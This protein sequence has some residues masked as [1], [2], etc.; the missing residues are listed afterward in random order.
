METPPPQSTMFLYQEVSKISGV[1]DPYFQI[2]QD[3]I[4]EAL[5]LYPELK[6]I[7][8]KSANP[9]LTAVR[10]AIAG[11]VIDL[12][13]NKHFDIRQDVYTIL[14]QQFGIDDFDKFEHE[15]SKA[16]TILY[17]GD[18]SGESVFDKILIE[19]MNKKVYYA[20]RE[21]P[22]INDVTIKEAIDSGLDEVSEIISSGCIAPAT[23]LNQCNEAFLTLFDQADLIISKGQGNYEGLSDSSRSVF[24]L[25]KAK[26]PIIAKDLNVLENDIVL[27]AINVH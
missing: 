12:G 15:L 10:I 18:N 23:L 4:K 19:Q 21:V 24:F 11:N 27:K 5:A 20:V 25:L 17:L 9:L 22:I 26:C 6:E 14:N 13:M 8:E 1:S 7:V 3:N 2:K 16:N